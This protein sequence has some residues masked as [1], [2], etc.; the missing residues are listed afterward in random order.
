[1]NL[2]DYWKK[3]GNNYYLEQQNSPKHVK[4][5]LRS[6]EKQIVKL[7]KNKNFNKIFELG[8]GYGR[9]TK[10]LYGELKPEKYVAIDISEGQIEN[11][12]NYVN[13][14]IEF[15]CVDFQNFNSKEKFDLVFSSEVLM[16]INSTDIEEVIKKMISLSKGKVI[17]LD[18]YNIEKIGSEVGGYCFM[19]DYSSLFKKCGAKS[20]K[21]HRLSLP[22]SLKII[23]T[24]SKIKQN[25]EPQPQA[26]IEVDV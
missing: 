1:M 12:R 11:A 10:I 26:I 7:F 9:F 8:C 24:Y 23:K 18:W 20:V 17:T 5:R 15:N 22:F 13:K 19:H 25:P 4:D 21:I 6:Q 16:H 14:K 2:K 3:R